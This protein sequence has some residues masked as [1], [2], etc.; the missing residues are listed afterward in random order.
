M[1]IFTGHGVVT[2]GM[3]WMAFAQPESAEQHPF[4]SASLPDRLHEV[5]GARRIKP[6]TPAKKRRKHDLIQPD[7]DD[8]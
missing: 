6:A 2:P 8:Q 5:C 1:R 4:E 7:H 3:K